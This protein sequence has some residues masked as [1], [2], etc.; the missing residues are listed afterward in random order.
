MLSSIFD[1]KAVIPPPP[2]SAYYDPSI[3][4]VITTPAIRHL[5]I[6][7]PLRNFSKGDGGPLICYETLRKMQKGA[8]I[9]SLRDARSFFRSDIFSNKQTP[10]YY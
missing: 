8:Y 7:H 6:I 2:P 10:F 3:I 9:V 1:F 5:V 4:C